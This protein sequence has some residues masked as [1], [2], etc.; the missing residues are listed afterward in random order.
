MT[1]L[2]RG[3]LPRELEI[4][5]CFSSRA[6]SLNSQCLE[7]GTTS[8]SNAFSFFVSL[9]F[10]YTESTKKGKRKSEKNWSTAFLVDARTYLRISSILEYRARREG[11]EKKKGE[12]KG[13]DAHT[14]RDTPCT[15]VYI[16]RRCSLPPFRPILSADRV[17]TRPAILSPGTPVKTELIRPP[18]K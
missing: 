4:P 12:E 1:G 16:S 11:E 7:I 14:W 15:P 13:K 3:E 2:I 8:S 17:P 5:R 18:D 6:V 9:F 10:S